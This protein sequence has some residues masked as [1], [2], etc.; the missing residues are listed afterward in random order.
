MRIPD[1]P[2]KIRASLKARLARL[3]SDQPL[4]A[5]TLAH[6]RKRCG[7]KTCRCHS[8]GEL[9]PAWHL[10]YKVQGKTTTVYVPFDLLDDV[11]KWIDNHK[12][13]KALLAEI[14]LLTVALIKS[15]VQTRKRK[16]GRP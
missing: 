8:H 10:T 14:H 5:A 1:H 9:H 4:L 6:I 7:R 12:R 13:H 16:A 2:T 11:R 15:H 3:G